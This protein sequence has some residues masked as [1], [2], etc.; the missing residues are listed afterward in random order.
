MPVELFDF[1]QVIKALTDENR[2]RIL[3]ALR[4]RELCVCQ[5]TGMLDLSPS[6]TSKHL[7]ILRQARLIDS[8]KKGKWVYYTTIEQD[9]GTPLTT[10]I[11]QLAVTHLAHSDIIEADEKHIR[12]VI[13]LSG[14]CGEDYD[15]FHSI[16]IHSVEN[17]TK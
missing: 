8:Q 5:I 13:S 3:M 7:S 12:E 2:V 1:M 4:G 6:T 9:P 11:I 16:A 10:D 17:E 15:H 14:T